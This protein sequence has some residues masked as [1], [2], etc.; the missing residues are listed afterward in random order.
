MPGGRTN[1]ND[2]YDSRNKALAIETGKEEVRRN[3]RS[4]PPNS[5][6][7]RRKANM[8]NQAPYIPSTD[9]DFDVWLANFSV[10][11]TAA[12]ILYGLTAPDALIVAGVTASWHSAYLVATNP[13]T[14]TSP[15]V[16]AKDGARLTA[17][18]T[19]RTYATNI[20]RNPG[21]S[22]L[23]KR[24]IGVNL[25]NNA[26]VPVPPITDVPALVLQPS[27]SGQAVLQYRSSSDPTRKAKPFGAIGIEIW[28][29]VGNVA[30]VSPEAG[31][32][33]V[34]VTKSP[35]V[36][37]NAPANNGQVMTFFGRWTARSGAGGMAYKGPWS[38]PLV[39]TAS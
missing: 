35:V 38:L 18:G 27:G 34:T 32:L 9:A 19:V 39:V 21:V 3:E 10:L 17:T 16:A 26:P 7:K 12:P 15:A 37:L 36:T 28:R 13:S 4:I 22:D 6:T 1:E 30:A 29:A 25:P 5:K 24:N 20:S 14:R 33:L 31:N 11:L 8:A 2:R 23:D